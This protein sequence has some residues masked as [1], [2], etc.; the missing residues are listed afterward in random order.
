MVGARILLKTTIP[1]I[2]DDWHIGRFSIL[3]EILSQA[4]H[5]VEMRDRRANTLGDDADLKAL[6][7]SD[8]D[9]LW[10]FAV[11]ED[12]A[13]TRGDIAAIN[14]FRRR[15]GG[16]M[17]TRDHEDLGA[18][19]RHIEDVGPAHH[20]HRVNKESDE[21][22]CRDDPYTEHI[23][24]PN[25][26]SGRNGDFQKIE[27]SAPHPLL[28]A[29]H[30]PG[31]L[32][33]TLPAHPHEG[34]VSVPR[35]ASDYARVIA[36]GRS[37]VTERAFNLAVAFESPDGTK[38]RAVAQSTFHHFADYNLDPRRGAPSFVT[39]PVG[40]GMIDDERANRDAETYI[41]NLAAW[42]SPAR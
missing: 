1:T 19:V 16:L 25:Y 9:Q 7:E 37:K 34:A 32:I 3:S 40:S 10:L 17:V 21:R 26:H 22:C 39:E 8:F 6:P 29:G 12:D 35:G 42:L 14:A 11:D 4:G 41:C 5:R 30:R 38:G 24:W 28:Q 27:V 2:T 15:G 31:G 33:A 36:T 18:S 23:S 20:F 13:L